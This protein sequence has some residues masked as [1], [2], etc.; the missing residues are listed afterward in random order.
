MHQ[1]QHA[2]DAPG[3]LGLEKMAWVAEAAFDDGLPSGAVEEGGL[4]R[5]LDEPIPRR[6]GVV[7]QRLNANL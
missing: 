2:G 1:G 7:L 5:F 6:R 3:A 4:G